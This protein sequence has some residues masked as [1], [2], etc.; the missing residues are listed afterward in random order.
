M[1]IQHPHTPFQT[2]ARGWSLI[3]AKARWSLC[4]YVF[5]LIA[6][7]VLDG[8]GLILISKI[9]FSA[10]SEIGTSALSG[11]LILGFWC[12]TVFVI[13]SCTAVYITWFGYLTLA[14]EETRLGQLNFKKYLRMR[15]ETLSSERVTGIYEFV[16]RGPNSL[17]Q[18][19][20]LSI[21]TLVAEVFG[22]ALLIIVILFLDVVTALAT[23]TFF[24]AIALLQHKIISVSSRK[25]GLEIAAEQTAT[26]DYL[27]D[28]FRL[29]KL[30][31]VSPSKSIVRVVDARRNS[32]AKA[33]ARAT[34]IESLPR[35][36]MEAT[37]SLGIV[38][39]SLVVFLTK[40]VESIFASL[41]IFMGAGFRILPSVNRIQGL[42]LGLIGR[43]PIANFAL[44]SFNEIDKEPDSM[45]V[46]STESTI[47]KLENIS[48][49][50]SIDRVPLLKNIS[51]EFKRGRY[52]AIVGPSG[53]GKS[54]LLDI[55]MGLLNPK[56]GTVRNSLNL[57]ETVGYVPQET[58]VAGASLAQNVALEW[59][60]SFIDF[61]NVETAL[62]L[63]GLDIGDI[64][65]ELEQNTL[66]GGQKQ[67]LGIARA[68][69]R[70]P[71]LLCLDEPTSAL[72][73]QTEF[74][75]MNSIVRLLHDNTTLLL[76]SHRLST[77]QNADEII[78][79]N[80]GSIEGVGTLSQLRL[81]IPN[82]EEQ[83]QLSKLS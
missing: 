14:R 34:F 16:D 55:C 54:T 83:I 47:L 37:L 30:L 15:W 13:R 45:T 10:A 25:A 81:R 51:F 32:L 52:Y 18:Q 66:S 68:L 9:N 23:I 62:Q 61:E 41:V 28:T 6:I 4:V 38:F 33:R 74:L 22:S 72:D 40:G 2:F 26:Y 36:L 70:K 17:I 63:A 1:T 11:N 53:S 60:D 48:F 46:L 24:L 69:Y 39:I 35:Y 78:Y 8:I 56:S 49:S 42:I 7:S 12:I 59:S 5:A 31:Q 80:N 64:S 65:Q 82:F 44:R 57:N 43:E 19:Y 76:V 67:R 58:Y 77:I 73:S 50:Y 79:L 27:S 75:V 20:I 29:A 71:T 21:A 3:S